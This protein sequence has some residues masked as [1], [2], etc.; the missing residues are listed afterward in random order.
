M[1]AFFCDL[2]QV[3]RIELE[4]DVPGF[5]RSEMDT[6]ESFERAQ[7]SAWRRGVLEVKLRDFIGTDLGCITDVRLDGEWLASLQLLGSEPEI[8]VDEARIA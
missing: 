6:L 1:F 8:T 7:G 5:T 3:P 4:G 2:A